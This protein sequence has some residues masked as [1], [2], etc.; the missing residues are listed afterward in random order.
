MQ[1]ETKRRK[2]PLEM[3]PEDVLTGR[4]IGAAIEVAGIPGRREGPD[5]KT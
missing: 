3:R 2:G 4:I 5:E 1:E